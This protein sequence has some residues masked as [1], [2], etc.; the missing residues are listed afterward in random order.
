MTD[1]ASQ[2]R[3]RYVMVVLLKRRGCAWDHPE[4]VRVA[5]RHTLAESHDEAM[6]LFQLAGG[7][8]VV[9]S[10]LS[11]AYKLSASVEIVDRWIQMERRKKHD[12]SRHS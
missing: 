12:A 3:R 6:A 10:W 9:P 8:E 7:F 4:S 11:C 1:G 5:L 2:H